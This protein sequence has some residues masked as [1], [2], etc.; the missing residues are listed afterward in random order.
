MCWRLLGRSDSTPEA[1][2]PQRP[3]VLTRHQG[4]YLPLM[5]TTGCGGLSQLQN[6]PKR[7]GRFPPT[8]PKPGTRLE[9]VTPSLPFGVP[10]RRCS[11]E[12]WRLAGN[13][14]G[15]AEEIPPAHGLPF[16][17]DMPRLTW[18]ICHSWHPSGRREGRAGPSQNANS[19]RGL[20]TPLEPGA[21]RHEVPHPDSSARRAGPA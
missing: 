16:G 17:R 5:A 19:D 2:G 14:W 15:S 6:R 7:G 18:C 21:P 10:R 3:V 8:S 13:L 20:T 11:V 9:L 12:K 1:A 4:R